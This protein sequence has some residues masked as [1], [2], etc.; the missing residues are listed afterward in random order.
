MRNIEETDLKLQYIQ[1]TENIIR[2]AIYPNKFDPLLRDHETSNMSC[3]ILPDELFFVDCGA[4]SDLARMFREDM[5][6]CYSRPTTHLFLT[7]D[8]WHSSFG[9]GAFKD[10]SVVMSSAGRSHFRRNIKSG[11]YEN[12]GEYLAR[13]FPDDEKLRA[14]LRDVSLFLPTISV[15]EDK[16]F[17][18]KSSEVIFKAVGGHTT[19]SSTVYVPSE[20]TLFAGGNLNTINVQ[21][22]WFPSILEAYREWE[23]MDID[24]IVPGH[25]PV[26]DK[27][28]IQPIRKYFDELLDKLR[29]LKKLGLTKNQVAKRTDL[30]EYPGEKLESWVEGSAQYTKIA[31]SMIK[32]WYGQVLKEPDMD[33]EDMMFIR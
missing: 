20:K 32:S 28:Y 3:I 9:M 24:Y 12:W 23:S 22:A 4:R 18:Y 27:G 10:V 16:A 13:N 2:T 29:E 1:V 21:F 5:E 30:S 31:A 11:T 33:E 6:K 15:P 14:S 8:H 7:H 19:P 25:G 26:V 17:G